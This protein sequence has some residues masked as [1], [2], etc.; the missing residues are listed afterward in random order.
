MA[1]DGQEALRI[2]EQV[3]EL[4]LVILDVMMPGMDGLE[5]C[6]RLRGRQGDRYVPIILATA[7][8]PDHHLEQGLAA[9]ADDYLTKPFNQA[10]VLARIRTALRLKRALDGLLEARELAT[11]AAMAVTLGHEINNPLAVVMGNLQLL[12]NHGVPDEQTRRKL[13]AARDATEHIQQLLQRL[14]NMKKVVTTTYLGEV[15]ML[16][17]SRSSAT[18]D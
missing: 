15:Q 5:V 3:P 2:A 14:A 16:D 17:L 6:R 1:R 4:S 8:N 18:S 10:E 13:Q 7:L 12:L 9:G 11:A